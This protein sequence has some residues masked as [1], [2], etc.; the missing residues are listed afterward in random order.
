MIVTQADREAL[1]EMYDIDAVTERELLAGQLDSHSPI[2]R[3]LAVLLHHLWKNQ[4]AYEPFHQSRQDLQA[5]DLSL[6]A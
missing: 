3:K 2:A 4:E 5:A 1:R 6:A